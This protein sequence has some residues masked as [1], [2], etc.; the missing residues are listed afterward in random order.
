MALI[1]RRPRGRR[2]DQVLLL[3]LAGAA[4]G[5]GAGVAGTADGERGAG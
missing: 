5:A 1:M 3:S 2:G 4:A